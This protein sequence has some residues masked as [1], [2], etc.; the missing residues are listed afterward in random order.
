MRHRRD[1]NVWI[2][3]ICQT[4]AIALSVTSAFLLRLD[5]SIPASLTPVLKQALLIAILMKLP[6]FEWAGFYRG[7]R[8]FV[9]I[10]DLYRMFLGNLAGSVLFTAVSRAWIGPAMPRSVW[11]IDALFCFV[12][13]VLVRFSVR[14]RNETFLFGRSAQQRVGILIYGAGTAGADLLREMRS[15]RSSRYEVKGFLDDNPLKWHALILGVPVLGPGRQVSS[16]VRQLNRRKPTVEEIIIAMPS[17]TGAQMREAVANCRAARITYKTIPSVDELLNA[18][19]S[20]EHVRNVSVHDLL[21]REPVK[22]D[23]APVRARIAG[24]S[25][26][27]TGAAGSIG[28]EL[29][30][31]VARFGPACLVAFDQAESELF[32]IENELREKYP[33]LELVTALGDIRDA[34]RLAEVL[35]RRAVESVFHAA[36]YKHVPMMESHILEAVRNN[37]IG[38]WN[39]VCAARHQNVRSLLMI[40][41]DKAVNPIC[42]MGATKRVCERIVSGRPPANVGTKCVSVRFGNVLG[43]SGSVVPAFQAQIAAGGPVKVTHPDVRRFFMTISEAV[44][45]VVQAWTKSQGSEIFVLDMGEPIRIVDLAENMIRLAGMIPYEDIDIQFTG[46]RPGEKLI[47]EI[48]GKNEGM[49]ATCHE[50]MHVIREEPLSWDTIAGWINE[51][52]EL[53]TA[54]QEEKIIEHIRGLVPEYNPVAQWAPDQPAENAFGQRVRFALPSAIATRRVAARDREAN[55]H[56]DEAAQRNGASPPMACEH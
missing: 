45:L 18:K 16:V 21:G 14:I 6:A 55:A 32:K 13:T 9:S 46:L 26:L 35:D 51:L 40:S 30:R 43:S 4:A 36:A 44:S 37:I 17:A 1:I 38:T 23:E 20:T 42:V 47:E 54:R 48:S 24:H 10:P 12:T 34:D 29:C 11:I 39:L 28:S 19:V 56:P 50:K 25:I 22:L 49:C 41:S 7:L 52:E 53:I 15:N 31:Q 33:R 8:R 3:R 5:F 27:V 2:E